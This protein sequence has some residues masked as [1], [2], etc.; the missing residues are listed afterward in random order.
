[1]LIIKKTPYNYAT[2]I[3][4][5]LLILY[6]LWFDSAGL[7]AISAA[8][9]YAF[10][11]IS[12]AY[13]T[14][15]FAFLLIEIFQRK[16]KLSD[17]IR[18]IKSTSATQRF[19]ALY[20]FFT[21]LSALFSP[22]RESVFFGASRCEGLLTISFYCIG[23]FLI[24]CFAKPEKW[25]LWLLSAVILVFCSIAFLQRLNFNP[26]SLYP[27]EQTP[28]GYS[29]SFLSTIGN[30]DFVAAFLCIVIP[31][32]WVTILRRTGRKRLLL[33]IPLLFSIVTLLLINVAAGFVGALVG[34]LFS[35]PIV[36]PAE[37]KIR[38]TLAVGVVLFFLLAVLLLYLF[39]FSS[40]TLHEL[41]ELLNGR[42]KGSF[43]TYRIAIWKRVL[44]KIPEQLWFGSG[45]D[46]MSLSDIS[47]IPIVN[48]NNIVVRV[49]KL[50][51]AHNEYLNILFHQGIFALLAYLGALLFAL[52]S[53]VQHARSNPSAAIFGAAA[54]TYC[55]QAF[56]S[57]SQLITAPFFWCSL[58]LLE[59]SI[60]N[61]NRP[62]C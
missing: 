16:R 38:R 2:N 1:M 8:K 33:L 5:A 48:A 49:K 55:I 7:T 31:I 45:P 13:F 26:F 6:V 17:L 19:I 30:I 54:L 41:H 29:Q 36:I 59:N 60:R 50:D 35:L 42:L 62:S 57:I 40:V 43:G 14:S 56:F 51:C 23:F 37:N 47:R 61:K 4:I 20:F 39:D 46:T 12:I 52:R 21:L 25:M 24:S 22:Y 58:A 9:R 53:W 3:Y 11:A 32:F 27:S 10:Y 34:T 15:V 18:F 28:Q 44:N